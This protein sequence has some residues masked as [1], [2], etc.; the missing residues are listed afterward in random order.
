MNQLMYASLF[1]LLTLAGCASDGAQK[2]PKDDESWRTASQRVGERRPLRP[3]TA[4]PMEATI[5]PATFVE[6]EDASNAGPLGFLRWTEG[7]PPLVKVENPQ[8][9]YND[10][11]RRARIQGVVLLDL[12]IDEKGAVVRVDVVKELPMGLT[13]S[14]V[15]A[16]KKFKYEPV[17]VDEKAIRVVHRETLNFRLQ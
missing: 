16:A 4:K 1:A 8:P 12:W 10:E 9:R 17:V 2:A 15:E 14:A 3:E 7:M 13:D 11:A 5:D 6:V